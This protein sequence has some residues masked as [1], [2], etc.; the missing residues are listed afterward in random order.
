MKNC[1]SLL[2]NQL[3]Y[4]Y[5]FMVGSLQQVTAWTFLVKG[6]KMHRIMHKSEELPKCSFNNKKTKWDFISD[7]F[8]S[9][10]VNTLVGGQKEGARGFMFF[11]INVDLTEEGLRKNFTFHF[12]G[13][14]KPSA[15]EETAWKC[16]WNHCLALQCT[17]KTSYSTCSSTS[18]S[19]ALSGL[20]N[21]FLKNARSFLSFTT[22][23]LKVQTW[24]PVC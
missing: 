4:V 8:C 10:W 17:L 7:P 3:T 21:G 18:R 22:S 5:A 23:S 2:Q 16:W 15:R 1:F 12:W 14:A 6:L 24:P 13:N 11:I 9:G 19:Y 20:R